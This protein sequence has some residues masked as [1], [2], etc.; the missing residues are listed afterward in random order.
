MPNHV[1]HKITIAGYTGSEIKERYSLGDRDFD[2]DKLIPTPIHI[3]QGNVSLLDEKDFM[4]WYVWNIENWGTKWN[5]YN[6]RVN[7]SED[8]AVIE[9]DTAWSIPYPIIVVLAN[10]LKSDCMTHE[11]FDE[12]YNFWGKE[13]W[14]AET[15][16]SKDQSEVLKRELCIKLKGYD[17]DEVEEEDLC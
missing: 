3:Y 2:F 7:D 14:K 8:G 5:C 15:R 16:I 6:E 13:V 11:Y 10:Q 9:F 1:S 4:S 12:G 17:P